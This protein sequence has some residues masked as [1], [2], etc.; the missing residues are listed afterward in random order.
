VATILKRN[1]LPTA[2]E[3]ERATDWQAFIEAHWPGLVASDVATWEVPSTDTRQT[4]RH[5]AYYAIRVATREVRLLGV[6]DR[7]DGAW[8]TQCCR[9]ITDVDEPFMDGVTTII[10]D[11]DPLYTTAARTCLGSDGRRLE[12]IAPGSP[13]CNGFIERFIGTTRREVGRRII[14][15]SGDILERCLREHVSY[16]NHVR[17]HQGLDGRRIPRPLH[18]KFSASD[19]EVIRRSLLGNVLGYYIREA[20]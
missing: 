18:D 20:A 2:P 11:G 14:P 16:Y 6:T 19:G 4:Q 13:W 15:F 9:T 10:H 5:H 8:V 7:A 1:G 12:Q 3:R 17:T